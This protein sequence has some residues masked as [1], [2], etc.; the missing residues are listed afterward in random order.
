MVNGENFRV[1]EEHMQETSGKKYA[2]GNL[3]SRLSG[4]D[5]V[6]PAPATP[7]EACV[8]IFETGNLLFPAGEFPFVNHKPRMAARPGETSRASR[9]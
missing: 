9:S 8:E 4:L 3:D 5:M 2:T 7:L 1:G 6:L